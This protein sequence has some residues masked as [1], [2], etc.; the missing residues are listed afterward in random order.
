MSLIRFLCVYRLR[1]SASPS[2]SA[3]PLS[4]MLLSFSTKEDAIAFAEKNGEYFLHYR[5]LP[6]L[7]CTAIKLTFSQLCPHIKRT[8]L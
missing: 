4:N 2:L 1:L 7:T 3:D 8:G 6:I 5:V